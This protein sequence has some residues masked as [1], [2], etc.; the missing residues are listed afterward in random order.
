MFK[1]RGFTLIE[2]LISV[3]IIG[4]LATIGI[5]SYSKAQSIARDSKRKQDLTNLK[6]ALEL[7]K[8]RNGEYPPGAATGAAAYSSN[9]PSWDT[10]KNILVPTGAG[11]IQYINTLPQDPSLCSGVSCSYYY[12]YNTPDS[13]S[14]RIGAKLEN[15]ASG[16]SANGCADSAGSALF[17]GCNFLLTNE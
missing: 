4:V 14:F 16:N 7:Y 11:T 12:L 6:T 9:L 10:F 1:S 3:A 15:S 8:Q 17:T 13:T 2:I 5:M